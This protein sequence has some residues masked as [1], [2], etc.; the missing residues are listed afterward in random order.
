MNIFNDVGTII[1]LVLTLA[2]FSGFFKPNPLYRFAESLFIGVSAGYFAVTW[3]FSII[4][5]AYK[6]ALNGNLLILIP[7]L[8]GF[9]LFIP[10]NSESYYSKL[11]FLPAAFIVIV[12]TAINIPIYFSA[13]IQEMIHSSIIPL[14]SFDESGNIRIDMTINAILSIV[15]IISAMMFLVARYKNN[16]RFVNTTG[17]IG[18]FFVLVAIGSAFAYTLLSRLIL[19]MGKIEFIINAAKTGF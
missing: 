16:N 2:V 5:P 8:A 18:R 15:C 17:E 6:S 19:F 14:L 9:L 10:L 13:F 3:Y 12:T 11:R 4:K 7:L 1:A